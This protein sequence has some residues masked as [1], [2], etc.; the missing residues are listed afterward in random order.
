MLTCSRTKVLYVL[1]CSCATVSCVI[2]CSRANVSCVLSCS[3]TK[4]LC[5]L[6]SSR[7]NMSCMLTCSRANVSCMLRALRAYVLTCQLALSAHV[8]MCR[9]ALRDYVPRCQRPFCA[10]VLSCQRVLCVYMLTPCVLYVLTRQRALLRYLRAITKIS[11]QYHVLSTSLWLLFVFFLWNKTV[12][13]FC[14]SLTSQKPL[15]ST[16]SVIF[17]WLIKG[18]ICIYKELFKHLAIAAYLFQLGYLINK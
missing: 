10:Y 12:A 1:M 6:T 4:V 9:R 11:F 16:L 13:H 14:T 17:K 3:R 2:T 15:E 5:T 7:A 8:L 18:E